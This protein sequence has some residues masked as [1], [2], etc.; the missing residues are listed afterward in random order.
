VLELEVK[1]GEG[2]K[3]F[4]RQGTRRGKGKLDGGAIVIKAA[5]EQQ[6]VS[7]AGTE[8]LHHTRI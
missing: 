5:N 1:K 2:K 8:R 4:L 3:M 6:H 7:L